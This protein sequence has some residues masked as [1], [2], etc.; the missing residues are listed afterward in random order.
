MRIITRGQWGARKFENPT[1]NHLTKASCLFVHHSESTIAQ[2]A[3]ATM[4]QEIAHLKNIESF[5][6]DTRGWSAIAYNFIVFPSGRVYEGRGFGRVPAA[7]VG[8]NFGHAAVCFIGDFTKQQSTRAARKSTIKLARLFVGKY[9]GGHR[10]VVETDCPGDN[11][12]RQI[13]GMAHWA[14]K[15]VYKK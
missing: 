6:M 14:R 7:Q 9:M 1:V 5:H 12:Y 13:P 11:L 15:R 4:A 8:S 3:N 2:G 10:D